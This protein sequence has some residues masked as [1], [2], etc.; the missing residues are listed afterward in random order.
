MD[1][2]RIRQ[3]GTRRLGKNVTKHDNNWQRNSQTK[4]GPLK[5]KRL[6][7][8]LKCSITNY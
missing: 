6:V 3:D 5:A 8:W 4:V 2:I 1:R 7:Q